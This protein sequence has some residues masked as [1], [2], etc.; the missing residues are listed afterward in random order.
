MQTRSIVDGR[1]AARAAVAIVERAKRN[2]FSEGVRVRLRSS[3][4]S[5]AA[6]IRP[7]RRGEEV[8]IWVRFVRDLADSMSARRE[9]GGRSCP[10]CCCWA[11]V[12]EMTSVTKV[13]SEGEFTLGITI[14]LRLGD[15]SCWLVC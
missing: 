6:K 10:C 9:I 3:A 15:W 2:S 8:H 11:R 5:S 4:K 1:F 14:V 13:R 12:C 7:W